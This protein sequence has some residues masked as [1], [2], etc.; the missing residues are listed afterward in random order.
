MSASTLLLGLLVLSYVGS[1]LGGNRT[2]RGFG[3]HSGAEYLLLGVVLGPHVL[4]VMN[5]SL[6]GTFEPILIVGAA[7]LALVAGIRFARVGERSVRLSRALSGIAL[8]AL[9]GAGVAAAVYLALG[10]LGPIGYNER[11]LWSGAAGAVCSETTRHAVRWVVERHGARGPLSDGI[12]DLARVS[13]LVPALGL[14]LLFAFDSTPGLLGIGFAG[15]VGVMLGV[16]ALLGL[17]A[18]WLLGREF[19]R[20]ESWGILLGTSLLGMGVSERLG[21][22]AVPTTFAMGLTVALVSTHRTELKAMI[23]PTEAPVMLPL[24]VLAGAFVELDLSP[25]I[26]V[27][28]GVTIVARLLLELGRGLLLTAFWPPARRAPAVLGLGM[29]SPGAL[30]LGC[31]VALATYF[32]D[33]IGGGVL[34]IAAAGVLAG[35]LVGPLSLRR[36]LEASG[37]IVEGASETPPPVTDPSTADRGSMP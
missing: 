7:W 35:E 14:A 20:D 15:R 26:P 32:P 6:L 28:L 13:S 12:A 23:T 1:I 36:A 27:L 9:I 3:L 19:R 18:T 2:I 5:R 16:G 17:V 33:P 24:T 22:S 8:S 30:S 34:V 10:F 25:A 29:A 37:E 11:W 21:F 31:A 4:G